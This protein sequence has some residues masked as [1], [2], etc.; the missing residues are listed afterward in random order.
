MKNITIEIAKGDT[1]LRTINKDA[2]IPSEMEQIVLAG[3][4]LEQAC[5]NLEIRIKEDSHERI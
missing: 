2:V 5:G 3:K 1:V 4:Q